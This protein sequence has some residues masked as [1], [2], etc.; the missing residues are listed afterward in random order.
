MRS[1]F[2]DITIFRPRQLRSTLNSSDA[3]LLFILTVFAFWTRFWR[4]GHP[5]AVVFDEVHFGSFTNSYIKSEFF[6]DIHPPLGK[7]VMFLG[8][9]LSEYDG[10]IDF[11]SHFGRGYT[12]ESFISLRLTP[13]FFSA[14]CIPLIYFTVRFEGFSSTS[15]FVAAF[16]TCCD[17]SL[18][19]EGRY[20]LSD[21][22]LHFF[23]CLFLA[24]YSF[25]RSLKNSSFFRF[26]CHCLSGALLGA[27]CSCKNTAWGLM[28]YS[29]FV[30]IIEIL[31]TFSLCDPHLFPIILIRG[32]SLIVPAV[33]VYFFSF[34]LHFLVLPYRGPGTPFLSPEMQHQLVP[35][36]GSTIWWTWISGVGLVDRTI[37]LSLEMH[38]A[39][40]GLTQSHPYQSHPKSWP[41]LTG[42]YVAFHHTR[43]GEVVCAGNAIVYWAAVTGLAVSTIGFWSLKWSAGLKFVVGWCCC[44]FPFFLI[45]RSMYL[46]HYLIP[47]LFGC[48]AV[49]AGIDVLCPKR[50]FA[51]GFIAFALCAGALF[52]FLLW[53]PYSYGTKLF[54]R[55]YV[56]WSRRWISGVPR[57]PPRI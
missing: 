51:A 53:S 38:R 49:G 36:V 52:G 42:I 39:N 11:E 55:Y 26:F 1:Y 40:M 45:A 4:L 10:S 18:L 15:S 25:T 27:A 46:Y 20:I 12:D 56:V 29:G 23:T 44:Y 41:F 48:C 8:A 6:F 33:T 47:L 9:S 50:R 5:W 13:S 17:S 14:L 57:L 24:F 19:T 2:I 7:L 35:K 54:N 21:G 28:P 16:L 32:L 37:A 22:L 34:F 31:R 3:F 43:E 30:E